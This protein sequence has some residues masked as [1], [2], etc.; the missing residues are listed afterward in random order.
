MTRDKCGKKTY[1]CANNVGVKKTLFRVKNLCKILRCLVKKVS[2]KN[3][4][5][6]GYKYEN[7]NKS[8]GVYLLGL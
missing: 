4:M 7:N 1:Q 2:G 3:A 8:I 6:T 5:A